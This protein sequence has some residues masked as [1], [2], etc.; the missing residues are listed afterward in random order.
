MYLMIFVLDDETGVA[1]AN[2]WT[3]GQCQVAREY[4]ETL[5][6]LVTFQGFN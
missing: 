4:L 6:Y 5:G 1:L 2:D 3:I